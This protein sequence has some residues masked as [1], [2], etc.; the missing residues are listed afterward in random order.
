MR[1]IE[2]TL[3]CAMKKITIWGTKYGNFVKDHQIQLELYYMKCVINN[4]AQILFIFLVLFDQKI[5]IFY[6]YNIYN[7]T[8]G[9]FIIP[10]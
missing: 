8:H 2:A 5:R 9:N 3:Q 6:K 4:N 7:N 10:I 1:I